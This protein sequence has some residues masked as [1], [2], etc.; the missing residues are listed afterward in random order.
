MLQWKQRNKRDGIPDTLSQPVM[1]GYN[2]LL[3]FSVAFFPTTKTIKKPL[4]PLEAV[5]VVLYTSLAENK[6]QREQIV[7]R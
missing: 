5:E 3:W 2:G 6:I 4:F 1:K 7:M